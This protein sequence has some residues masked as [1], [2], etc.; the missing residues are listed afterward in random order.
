META[1]W[2]VGAEYDEEALARLGQALRSLGYGLHDEWQGVAGSQDTSHWELSGPHGVLTVESETYV[3]LSVEGPSRAVDQL[4]VLY[5]QMP[6][7][8][9]F[10]PTAFGRG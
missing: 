3:G 5:Q 10:Q 2:I 9:S 6:S 8:P 1:H 4:R 7:N